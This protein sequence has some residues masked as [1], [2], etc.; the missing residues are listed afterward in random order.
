MT[1]AVSDQTFR[2]M[3]TES[4]VPVLLHFAGPGGETPGPA[5]DAAAAHF[6][7][8]LRIGSISVADN[9]RLSQR[10]AVIVPPVLIVFRHGEE[11]AR[12]PGRGETAQTLIDWLAPYAGESCSCDRCR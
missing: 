9:P 3:V 2:T 6:G 4:P 1:D 10:Y 8:A 11:V 12:R 5:L 7:G